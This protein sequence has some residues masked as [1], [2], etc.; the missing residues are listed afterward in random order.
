LQASLFSVADL[1][2]TASLLL[3]DL[4]Y[5][6]NVFIGSVRKFSHSLQKSLIYATLLTVSVRAF[7]EMARVFKLLYANSAFK[8]ARVFVYVIDVSF[9]GRTIVE[10]F[11]PLVK[12]SI[13]ILR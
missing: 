3:K 9:E 2:L 4:V 8:R 13:F 12:V 5:N 1:Q 6:F 10:V 11:V 7:F